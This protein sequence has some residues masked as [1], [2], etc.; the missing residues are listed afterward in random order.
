VKNFP[1][2]LSKS[3]RRAKSSVLKESLA[4]MEQPAQREQQDL[5]VSED[6]RVSQVFLVFRVNPV[7]PEI[8]E[9]PVF[10]VKMDNAD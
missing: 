9:L 4:S 1:H 10:Q 7:R 5:L 6:C 8:G 2:L 3:L